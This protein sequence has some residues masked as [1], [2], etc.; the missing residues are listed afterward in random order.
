MAAI[1]GKRERDNLWQLL[2]MAREEDLGSSG[3][4]TSTILPGAVTAHALF[5]A[6]QETVF[7]GGPLLETMAISYDGNIHTKLLVEEGCRVE[8]GTPL[9]EWAGPAKGIMAAERVALNFL[10]HLCAVATT[11]RMYVDAVESTG[12]GIYDTRK[13]TPAW[14]ELEKY[15]VRV[16]GG[17]NHRM[18]LYDAVLIKDNH[19]AVLA[20]EEQA[21][22]VSADIGEEL[23][24]VRPFLSVNAFIELEVDTLEQFEEALR[25]PVDIIMLDNMS[26]DQLR[27]AVRIRREAGLADRIELEASGGI[28]LENVRSVAETGVERIAIGALTH[29]AGS[30]D[31]ALDIELD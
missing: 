11:T 18:G 4:I 9:A 29:S 17:L 20:R 12:V 5:R 25:L 3:D 6:R 26:N 2:Q 22:G 13:T 21:H 30:I 28:T 24:R 14:R 19:L 1:P 23:Q 8:A 7:C 10:Q 15:A 31:I 16:G 27:K